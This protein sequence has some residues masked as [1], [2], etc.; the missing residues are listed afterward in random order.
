MDITYRG[1]EQEIYPGWL[2]YSGT[3]TLLRNEDK[4]IHR[5]HTLRTF[6]EKKVFIEINEQIEQILRESIVN[7]LIKA[8]KALLDLSPDQ[9]TFISS[10]NEIIYTEKNVFNSLFINEQCP[11]LG[12][13]YM[14]EKNRIKGI[15]AYSFYIQYYYILVYEKQAYE[16]LSRG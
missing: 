2:I 13:N 15:Q 5:D 7:L 9:C 6:V 14:T 11:Q 3:F 12:K 10:G 1:D 8:R 16:C 4:L